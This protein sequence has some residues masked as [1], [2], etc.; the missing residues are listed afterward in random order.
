MSELTLP[1]GARPVPPSPIEQSVRTIKNILI[2]WTVVSVFGALA[3]VV[4]WAS[5][6]SG[7]HE[8]YVSPYTVDEQPRELTN[9]EKTQHLRDVNDLIRR[10][11]EAT[12][13]S[14]RK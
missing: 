2:W 6:S 3:W 5:S 7:A 1:T 11:Y 9:E 14:K 13:R 10:R 12:P 8:A 4:V